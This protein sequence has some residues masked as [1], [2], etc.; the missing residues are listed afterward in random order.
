VGFQHLGDDRGPQ[1]NGLH[2]KGATLNRYLAES[3]P[4]KAGSGGE[5]RKTPKTAPL[6]GQEINAAGAVD[7]LPEAVRSDLLTS[8]GVIP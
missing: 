8:P 5:R 1:K 2:I 3:Q 4:L 7:F 6:S